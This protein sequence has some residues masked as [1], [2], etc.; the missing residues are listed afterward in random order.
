MEKRGGRDRDDSQDD[1][2]YSAA[3]KD[4]D[5]YKVFSIASSLRKDSAAKRKVERD[6]KR[7]LL[8]P[9]VAVAYIYATVVAVVWQLWPTHPVDTAIQVDPLVEAV[10]E[11]EEPK[12]TAV[13]AP[14]NSKPVFETKSENKVQTL[15]ST[16]PIIADA[17]AR[18]QLTIADVTPH[19]NSQGEVLES[20]EPL[21]FDSA[22][23]T[24]EVSG[25]HLRVSW[26][27]LYQGTSG[28]VGDQ[29][30]QEATKGFVPKS[31]I[32]LGSGGSSLE[33]QSL[34][35]ISFATGERVNS[36]DCTLL[37]SAKL[38]PKEA[39]GGSK[40]FEKWSLVSGEA[41]ELRCPKG[42][43]V[44][45]TGALLRLAAGGETLRTR[46]FYKVENLHANT[47]VGLTVWDFGTS[48]C[49]S[50]ASIDCFGSSGEVDGSP[51]IDPGR[52]LWV[53]ME[54]PRATLFEKN[55]F[56]AKSL[57]QILR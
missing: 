29:R 19:L 31:L 30:K 45:W 13:S 55:L 35:E 21:N 50:G 18:A 24:F 49:S 7:S 41:I 2:D 42:L 26:G 38:Q 34:F 46:I 47:P 4:H 10:V 25:D 53:G 43:F 23:R 36:I 48:A 54:H 52:G 44:Q 39:K 6:R 15:A 1:R 14:T 16:A 17:A 57:Q 37:R 28:L 12:E 8:K 5:D 9:G 27:W 56:L 22:G 11:R 40:S 20:L 33:W 51:L 3:S 32:I